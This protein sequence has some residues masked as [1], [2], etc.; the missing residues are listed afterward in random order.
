MNIPN[1]PFEKSDYITGVTAEAP[2]HN[3]TGDMWAL[4]WAADD[5][6]Y[7]G[8]GD[9]N[10]GEGEGTGF[11]GMPHWSPMNLWRVRDCP[12]PHVTPELI[13]N[14][15]VDPK[16]YCQRPRTELENGIKPAGLL[17]IQGVLYLAVENLTSVDR[18]E[19]PSFNRQENINGWI[20]TSQDFGKTWDVDATPQE[21]FRDRLSSP[22]FVQY[23][24]DYADAPDNYVYAVF[25]GAIDG[26]SY[27]D[28]GDYLLLGRVPIADLL[29]RD[30]W[31]FWTGLDEAGKPKW[32][33]D[34]VLAKPIFNYPG[35]TAE[36]H[37]A[38]NPGLRRFIMGNAG[39]YGPDGQPLPYH[40]EPRGKYKSQLT[41]YEAA[42]LWG[43]WRLFYRVDDWGTG[44]YQPSFPTK[45]MSKDGREMIMVSSGMGE[46]YNFT[47]ERLR[48]TR[49]EGSP[50]PR[51]QVSTACCPNRL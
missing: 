40:N 49:T 45:W 38:W 17:S 35:F 15:P 46:N 7:A 8:A 25:P 29:R 31:E 48:L 20:I 47:T 37:I 51:G 24:R 33:A 28:D 9:N 27:W 10:P 22:H 50:G 2:V 44:N 43:P 41:V 30:R 14:L 1:P 42:N 36:N 6:I 18:P 16:K 34:D 21:F 11:R 3:R 5:A 23:G 32:H 4:T 13:H 39:F 19:H 26:G 12:N